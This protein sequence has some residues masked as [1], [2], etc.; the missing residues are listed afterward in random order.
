MTDPAVVTLSDVPTPG[1][2]AKLIV[3]A[4][5]FL[6]G[7][8]ATH[9]LDK[10]PWAQSLAGLLVSALAAAGYFGHKAMLKQVHAKAIAAASSK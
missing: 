3:F 10:Y 7:L 6:S 1:W 5:A 4:I 8:P 2:S 9:L